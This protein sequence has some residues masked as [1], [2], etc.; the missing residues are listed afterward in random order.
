MYYLIISILSFYLFLVLLLSFEGKKRYIGFINTFLI[1]LFLT[2]I[3]GVIVII[4]S[5]HK[6]A[7]S[8]YVKVN[9]SYNRS[10]KDTKKA[11]KIS[12][13]DDAWI[14]IKESDIGFA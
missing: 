2:P 12:K 9:K 3:I 11:L 1:S 6:A 13:N 14:K 7:F 10:R 5:R 4:F 8:H